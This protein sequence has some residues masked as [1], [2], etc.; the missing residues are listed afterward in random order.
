MLK[1]ALWVHSEEPC[2]S[3]LSHLLG[4]MKIWNVDKHHHSKILKPHMK[5]SMQGLFPKEEKEHTR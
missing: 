2:L 5:T 3:A 4:A 1:R